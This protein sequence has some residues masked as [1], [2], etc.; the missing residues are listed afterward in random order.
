MN[1]F[2]ICLYYYWTFIWI[3]KQKK[4]LETKKNSYKLVENLGKLDNYLI[5]RKTK[6]KICKKNKSTRLNILENSK[7]FFS[8][9]E[10]D[11]L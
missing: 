2:Q 6:T 8:F 9:K 5:N 10:I 4:F 11:K 1:N 3:F 7:D